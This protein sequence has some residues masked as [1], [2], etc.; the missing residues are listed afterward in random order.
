MNESI[1]PESQSELKKLAQQ[2]NEQ[3]S[4][5]Q[6]QCHEATLAKSV[7][8]QN[9]E[10]LY[11]LEV[12]ENPSPWVQRA[13]D[14]LTEAGW[15][16]SPSINTIQGMYLPKE[17]KNLGIQGILIQDGIQVAANTADKTLERTKAIAAWLCNPA[18]HL[19]TVT[20]THPDTHKL[21][22][23]SVSEWARTWLNPEPTPKQLR[24][25]ANLGMDDAAIVSWII[26]PF[27]LIEITL[28]PPA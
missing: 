13:Y 6:K 10:V 20:W 27:D 22:E 4:N 3:Y 21:V 18:N 7:I 24:N 9:G 26:D 17:L 19:G 1:D 2:N 23:T 28:P 16:P 12:I 25:A 14:M 11:W 5:L 8:S 15:Q